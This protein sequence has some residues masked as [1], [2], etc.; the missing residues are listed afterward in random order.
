VVEKVFNDYYS[1]EY[2]ALVKRIPDEEGGGWIAEIIDLPGCIA[3]GETPDEAILNLNE[4]KKCWIDVAH[5]R[6]QN[7]PK[8]SPSFT[9]DEVYSGKFTL[10]IPKFLHRQLAQTAK[11]EGVSLNQYLQT[12]IAFNFGQTIKR[13]N[14]KQE[15]T[16]N[17]FNYNIKIQQFGYSTSKG[18]FNDLSRLWNGI[19]RNPIVCGF[20]PRG[21]I[22]N[23]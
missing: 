23:E 4:A 9:D 10:R 2:P 7:I 8:P 21:V 11:N 12:L 3:D 15:T 6:G 20:N 13:N 14:E 5:K 19:D 22:I 17:S 18:A 1:V 16:Q